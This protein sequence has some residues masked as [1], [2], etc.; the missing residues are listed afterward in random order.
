MR[1]VDTNSVRKGI[2]CILRHCLMNIITPTTLWNDD[3]KGMGEG[4]II[5]QIEIAQDKE[6]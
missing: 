4:T 6:K 2:R 3:P 1:M 5:Q